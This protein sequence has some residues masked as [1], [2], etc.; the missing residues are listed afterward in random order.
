MNRIE[1][2]SKKLNSVMDTEEQMMMIMDTLKETVTPVPDVG[3]FYTFVY[4]A[5]TPNVAYDQHP[6]VA[7]TAVYSWGFV[8]INMHWRKSRAYTWAEVAGQLY[9]VDYDEF[10]DL[11][12][13]NYGKIIDK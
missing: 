11:M 13:I 3:G 4:N 10:D 6:L 7:V 5:K 2:I 8:G 1:G 9:V 12:N